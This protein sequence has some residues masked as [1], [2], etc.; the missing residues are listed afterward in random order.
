[1]A[2]PAANLVEAKNS[3]FKLF[4]NNEGEESYLV[5]LIRKHRSIDIKYIQDIKKSKFKPKK[6][7]EAK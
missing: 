2:K 4:N 1:M 6:R 7:H 5:P 3:I